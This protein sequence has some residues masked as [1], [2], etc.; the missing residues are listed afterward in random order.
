MTNKQEII[1]AASYIDAEGHIEYK[2]RNKKNSRGKIYPCKSI[3]IEVCNTDYKP[4]KD[5]KKLFKC[6]F[7][8]YPKRRYKKNGELGKQ[9]IKWVVTHRNCHKVLKMIMPFQKSPS[10]IKTSKQIIKY[11][12]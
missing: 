1:Y 10:R 8:S 3:R 4:I 11:Y 2:T 7:I 12:K 9:Q 5:L 6:G